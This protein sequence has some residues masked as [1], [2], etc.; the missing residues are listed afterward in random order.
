MGLSL[1]LLMA[2]HVVPGQPLSNILLGVTG[3][4]TPVRG[5]RW[6]DSCGR[7]GCTQVRT[8]VAH[9]HALYVCARDK[10]FL[11]IIQLG[12]HSGLLLQDE[13]DVLLTSIM[14]RHASALRET[15]GSGYRSC[16]QG[17]RHHLD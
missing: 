3:R 11:P 10:R 1:L 15:I 13:E 9:L 2:S 5:P 4:I 16:W 8:C 12:S 7:G 17:L 14:L 6:P